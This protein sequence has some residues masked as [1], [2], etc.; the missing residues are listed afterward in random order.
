[1]PLVW[2][3]AEFLKLAHA[4]EHG[5]IEQLAAVVARWG[6]EPPAAETW[7]WRNSVP[8]A[9]LPKG[10]SLVIESDRPH[11]VHVGFDGWQR[12]EDRDA[13]AIG[14]GM[15]GARF[16]T[17]ELAGHVE[18]NFTRRYLDEGWEQQDHTVALG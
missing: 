7:F 1:M 18:L 9:R 17:S 3:H 2:A 5:P 4:R 16:D 8:F 6:R 13:V 10:R 15:Y 12:I 11:S 14:F